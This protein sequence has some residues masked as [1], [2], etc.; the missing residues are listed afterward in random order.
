[1]IKKKKIIAIIPAKGIS[2]RL[3]NKNTLKI[4]N[5]TLI[6]HTFNSARKS[7]YID[8][9]IVSTESKKIKKMSEKIGIKVPFLRPKSLS[10]NNTKSDKVVIH[11]LKKINQK[12]NYIVLL[13]PTSPL[14]NTKDID[15]SINKIFKNKLSTLVSVYRSNKKQKNL[16]KI[17]KLKYVK[18]NWKKYKKKNNY[19]LNG[20]IYI[21][22]IDYFMRFKNF[23]SQ[24]TGYHIM[25]EKRSIDIDYYD[26][27]LKA[28]KIL[29]EY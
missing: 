11:A 3:K 20:A 1:M 28:K 12:F 21:S 22:R 29:N 4:K 23:F 13:Q 8:Q 18:R 17:E 24:K 15:N 26:E 16:V 10:H 25:P 9:I 19:F 14:R 6:E 5:K 2:R 7:K 27:F